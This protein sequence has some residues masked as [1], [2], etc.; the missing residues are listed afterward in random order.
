[1]FFFTTPT[2]VSDLHWSP[3]TRRN[4]PF[5]GIPLFSTNSFHYSLYHLLV[6]VVTLCIGRFG[7]W[8]SSVFSTMENN[9]ILVPFQHVCFHPMSYL[10]GWF[11]LANHIYMIQKFL[12][13]FNSVSRKYCKDWWED[14]DHK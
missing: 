9:L 6:N 1:M 10:Y 3:T 12:F 2:S 14:G 7:C 5:Q 11:L 13:C 8:I 4:A